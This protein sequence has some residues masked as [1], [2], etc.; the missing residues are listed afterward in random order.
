MCLVILHILTN[1]ICLNVHI[2]DRT[3]LSATSQ[4]HKQK[5]RIKQWHM[6]IEWW[7]LQFISGFCSFLAIVIYGARYGDVSGG[8][9]LHVSYAFCALNFGLQMIIFFIS[10]CM[11]G[12]VEEHWFHWKTQDLEARHWTNNGWHVLCLWCT[13]FSQGHALD[14]LLFLG[15]H[16]YLYLYII[17]LSFAYLFIMDYF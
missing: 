12:T 5:L 11:L 8:M 15:C 9:T 3:P 17:Y 16:R 1:K 14:R 13:S 2:F 10:F 6:T 4:Q 7:F